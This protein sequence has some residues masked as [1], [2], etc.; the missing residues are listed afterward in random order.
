VRDV[1]AVAVRRYGCV[2]LAIAIAL[3]DVAPASATHER[4][5]TFAARV[6]ED[7]SQVTAN[8]A[9]NNIQESL[10]DLGPNTPYGTVQPGGRVIPNE[11]DP[12]IE[13]EFQPPP[14]EPG[15]R[16][17][18]GW[19]FRLGRNYVTKGDVGVWGALTHVTGEFSTDITTS[20]ST[21]L[22]DRF[23]RRVEGATLAGA[24]TI[25]LTDAERAQSTSSQSLWLQGGV[26]GTPITGDPTVYAFAALRCATDNLTGDNVEFIAYPT[27][28]VNHVFCFAYYVSPAP[29]PGRIIVTKQLDPGNLPS[30]FPRQ[31]VRFNGN[32]SYQLDNQGVRFFNL[33]AGPGSPASATFDR[34]AGTAWDFEEVPLSGFTSSAPTCTS[35]PGTGGSSSGITITGLRVVVDLAP[36]DTVRCTFVNTAIRPPVGQLLLRKVTRND[37]GVFDF[38]VDEVDGPLTG[39]RRIETEVPN[40]AHDAAP[41]T[42]LVPGDYRVTETLP[43][44]SAGTWL[45][46]NVFCDG[47]EETITGGDT[48]RVRVPST[49]GATC[50]F[51]DRFRHAGA[52]SLSKET[53]GGIGTTRFQIRPQA[54]PEVEFEQIARTREPGVRVDAQGDDTEHI[55]L[56]LYAIQETTASVN[57][58]DGLWRVVRVECDRAAEYSEGGRILV[59][60]TA[61][62]PRIHCHFVNQLLRIDPPDPE[63]IPPEPTPPTPPDEVPEG[64]VLPESADNLAEL[65]VTKVGAPRRITF[66]ERA[67][68][69][70]VVRNRGPATAR[71]VVIAEHGAARA[72][73]LRARTSKGSCRAGPPRFC[74]LGNLRSGRRVVI[75]V[76]AVPQR[77]GRLRNVVAVHTA[78]AQRTRRGKVARAAVVVVPSQVPRFTG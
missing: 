53:L 46:D 73:I 41:L 64:G 18:A 71:S 34:A 37:V 59:R 47:V 52:I 5:V 76:L 30:T 42:G 40:V 62:N 60:L 15:C 10:R 54:D 74:S 12:A 29:P 16:P 77:L 43:D 72:S 36:S 70:V 69:R 75:T 23:H 27:G 65:R 45:L 33:T 48:I 63:P 25:E 49:N 32:I 3:I 78:T 26:P 9:R 57:G 38:D 17:L 55:P 21:A 58:D 19:K 22:Y 20:A 13:A 6:C 44:S 51:T 35:T 24:T 67:R 7:F 39:S 66:G 2:L 11:V 1:H 8:R 68:Y 61:D 14:P 50:T 28:G 31:T 4:W 56:G